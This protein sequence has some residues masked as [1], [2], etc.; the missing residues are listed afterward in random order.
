VPR[1]LSEAVAIPIWAAVTPENIP[2]VMSASAGRRV[3]SESTSDSSTPTAT[4]PSV[5]IATGRQPTRSV[6]R[7]ASG[8]RPPST[9]R[10]KTRPLAVSSHP[11]GGASSRKVTY[12][13]TPTKARNAPAPVPVAVST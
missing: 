5:A 10:T 6:S 7:P 2:A 1:S 4:Q 3:T 8:P 9:H 13:K 11:N 12:E